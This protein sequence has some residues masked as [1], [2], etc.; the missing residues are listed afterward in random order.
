MWTPLLLCAFAWGFLTTNECACLLQTGINVSV[1][2]T[3]CL[4]CCLFST[5]ITRLC[6]LF[7]VQ[8]T[9]NLCRKLGTQ[10]VKGAEHRNIY[11]GCEGKIVLVIHRADLKACTIA[12]AVQM[13]Y[14]NS[15]VFQPLNRPTEEDILN[16][17]TEK[18]NDVNSLCLFA[19]LREISTANYANVSN[20]CCAVLPLG[21]GAEHR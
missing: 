14:R 9:G 5:N 21:S 16:G 8:R 15:R 20:E 1:L 6:R 11:S 2:C 18:S 12:Q 7:Q 13:A 17:A 19:P 4:L 10:P 3:S